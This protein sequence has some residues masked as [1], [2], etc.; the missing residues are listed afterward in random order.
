MTNWL[1]AAAMLLSGLIV[2]FMFIYGMKRR[3]ERSDLERRDLEAKRDALIAQLRAEGDPQERGRLE[4]EAA[5][6]LRK[7]DRV[8]PRPSAA[9]EGGG[10]P[11]KAAALK[12]FFWGAGSVA[13]LAAIGFFVMQSAKPKE[14]AAAAPS[15]SVAQLEQAVQKNPNDLALRDDLAKAYLDR[16]NMTGV[17]GQ[18]QYVLQ[19]SP[20]DARALTYEALVRIA[21]G[22]AEASVEMLQRATRSDPDLID[23][24]V[25]L[26]W[27]NAQNGKM[28]EARDAIGEAK[29]RHPDQA[30]RLDMLLSRF[31]PATP[32]RVTL[33]AAP[34]A[35]LAAGGV[36]FVIARAEG[37]TSGP[38]IA[39]KRLP[40][41]P[42][43]MNVEISS[44]D[45]MT[46]QQL[47][48][49]VRIEARLDSDGDPLTKSATD[50]TAVKDGVGVGESISLTL[51]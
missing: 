46:G 10:P 9:A 30:Q 49:R 4:L 35:H 16:E 27:V 17:V 11:Q 33:T 5:E 37:V 31:Q 51:H 36:I 20:D 45:S 13:V 47:P 18:T 34:S 38:P 28:S 44:A 1:N 41:G 3:E 6:V 50:L 43:P 2:G 21:M 32:I 24:W 22:Q 40:L 39:V 19:R 14:Q 29:R 7:L 12:G 42:F 8:G 23:A 15:D 48:S 25:G 26:A